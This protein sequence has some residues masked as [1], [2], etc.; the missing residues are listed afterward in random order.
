VR[1]CC[2]GP[3]CARTRESRRFEA[4]YIR[5]RGGD[6][7]RNHPQRDPLCRRDRRCCGPAGLGDHH[8]A[9]RRTCRRR[10]DARTPSCAGAPGTPRPSATVRANHLPF[11]ARRRTVARP[12]ASLSAAAESGAQWSSAACVVGCR[13]ETAAARPKPE[14]CW[15]SSAA[16]QRECG[17]VAVRQGLSFDSACGRRAQAGDR[18]RLPASDRRR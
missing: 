16:Q 10:H 12:R 3:T 11:R 8:T 6:D 1:H 13:I 4:L 18:D 9:P 7:R 2:R 17:L 5:N 14:D 15:M